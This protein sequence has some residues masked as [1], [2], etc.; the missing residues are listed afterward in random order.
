MLYRLI[1]LTGP[2][3]RQQITVDRAPMVIGSGPDCAIRLEDEEVTSRHAV[4]EHKG[5]GLFIRDLGSQGA[6]LVNH[7]EIRECQLKHGDDIEIGRTR[8]LVQARVKAEVDGAAGGDARLRR[9]RAA[10]VLSLAVAGLSGVGLILY[11]RPTGDEPTGAR[12]AARTEAERDALAPLVPPLP[13]AGAAAE[14]RAVTNQPAQ[15]TG[16]AAPAPSAEEIQ[17]IREDLK[18]IRQMM[19]SL[20]DKQGPTGAVASAGKAET[21]RAVATAGLPKS[22]EPGVGI[23]AARAGATNR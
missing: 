8:F 23:L 5:E 7:R 15:A 20:V 17:K 1:I 6:L 2:L 3:A 12:P 4:L 19:Q 11:Y 10:L 14:A 21:N 9:K 13:A 18:G 16:A 22:G